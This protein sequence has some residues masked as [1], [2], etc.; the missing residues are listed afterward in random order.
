M[1]TLAAAYGL[2][3]AFLG[4]FLYPAR[5]PLTQWTYVCREGD[6]NG[7]QS[8]VFELPGGGPVSV[9]RIGDQG[10][11]DDFI[12]LSSV[13]PHLGCTVQQGTDNVPFF[14]PCHKAGFHA[15]GT[16]L[17]EAE[18]GENNPTPRD[19][20]ALDWR[21]VQDETSEPWWVEV[22]Y[23]KFEQGRTDKVAVV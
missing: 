4:R 22:R 21:V 5:A 13:C 3:A 15:T 16:A 2:M 10:R 7:G 19:M 12:A 18:L 20:D 8:F 9:A 6:L 11:A 17:T 23:E 1:G 14:C